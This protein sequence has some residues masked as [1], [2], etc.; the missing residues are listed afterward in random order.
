M[1]RTLGFLLSALLIVA[2][3][4]PTSLTLAYLTAE[5]SARQ[6]EGGTG[7][8]CSVPA[9][10]K[11]SNVYRLADMPHYASSNSSLIIV[12]VVNN[13]EF[14]PG[15]GARTLATRLWACGSASL[16][17][18]SNVKITAWRNE[19]SAAADTRWLPREGTGF[20]GHR[21][22]PTGGF[23]KQIAGL[24]FTGS[25][26]GGGAYLE[27]SDR[28]KYTWLVASGRTKSNPSASDSCS[29]T[30]LCVINI[31][32]IPTFANA[33]DA[34]AGSSRSPNNSVE[35]RA[36]GFWTG[37]GVLAPGS[38]KEVQ[39]DPYTGPAAPFSNGQRPTSSSGRQV[40]WVVMEWWGSTA[41]SDDMV[42]EVFFA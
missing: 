12:P 20:A 23:G 7:R 32:P 4:V 5:D 11:Q 21:L 8:W 40:Q 2:L 38:P 22:D 17:S 6:T 25:L 9:P 41:P 16:T 42:I 27:G 34:N 3:L 1:T 26:P 29:T 14:G 24:H 15:G 18:G 10:E 13:G 28:S 31:G 37:D 36:A 35:Y 19:G 33:F 30:A 39:M